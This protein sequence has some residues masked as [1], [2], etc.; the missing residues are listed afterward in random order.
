MPDASG[1]FKRIFLVRGYVEERS[2]VV[3]P[4]PDRTTLFTCA[5][6]SVFK[7]KLLGNQ[8]KK[9]F[10]VQ[11]CLRTQNLKYTL[12]RDYDPEYLSS[13]LMFGMLCPV[14]EFELDCISDFF[15]CFPELNERILIRSSRAVA[16]DLFGAV[17]SLYPVEHDTR[18]PNYYTWGYGED[19][20]SGEGLTFALRQPN[21][22]YL[23][24]GN[25]VVI[26][27]GGIPLAVEFGFGEETFLARLRGVKTPYATSAK[28]Q[29]LGLG[30]TPSEKKMGD[31]L[32]TAQE[33]FA[34]GTR[35]G[36]GKAASVLRKALR[37][38]CFLAVREYGTEAAMRVQTLARCLSADPE[39]LAV[40]ADALSRAVA[41]ISAFELA[42][43]HIRRHV[44]GRYLEEKIKGY[45]LRYGIPEGFP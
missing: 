35:P 17:E 16:R 41:S 31:A 22:E 40:V 2:A 8:I 5:T 7:E 11:P 6:I 28:Y 25:F 10:V 20:L 29:S 26:T 1:T 37:L 21:G 4:C 24:I 34:C 38:T 27:R 15:A 36:T 42:V 12:D 33:I 14:Q 32:I 30:V 9:V 44:T 19:S 18:R 23:D 3:F 43:G 13:F 39:W 45:R